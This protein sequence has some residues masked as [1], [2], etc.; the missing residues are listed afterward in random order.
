MRLIDEC[1]FEYLMPGVLHMQGMLWHRRYHV[2]IRRVRRFI[3]LMNL[4]VIQ[5]KACLSEGGVPRYI[6]PYLL[7]DLEID[8]SK[9]VWI[10]ISPTSHEW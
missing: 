2:D 6:Y 3:C 10:Q 9:Q 5:P 7:R 1:Y 8:K 4:D